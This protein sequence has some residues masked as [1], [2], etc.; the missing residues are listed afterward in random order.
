M[1]IYLSFLNPEGNNLL[2]NHLECAD[3]KFIHDYQRFV[4]IRVTHDRRLESLVH[5]S[6]PGLE[7]GPIVGSFFINYTSQI[8]QIWQLSPI[9]VFKI[10]VVKKNF[11]FQFAIR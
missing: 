4:G 1:I 5:F 8:V 3:M 7:P 11:I 9:K 6:G 2:S 10:Y